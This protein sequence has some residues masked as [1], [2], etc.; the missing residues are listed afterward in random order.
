MRVRWADEE[1]PPRNL[2]RLATP[3]RLRRSHRRQ[4]EFLS[5]MDL[6][7]NQRE[8]DRFIRTDCLCQRN[9]YRLRS[10]N[11]QLPYRNRRWNLPAS[12]GK[13]LRRALRDSG[14]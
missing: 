7:D 4:E 14:G 6:L 3:Q 8:R 1:D 11:V 12:R 10:R 5:F 2:P 13:R 9:R